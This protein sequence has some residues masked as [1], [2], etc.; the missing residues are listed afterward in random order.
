MLLALH[1]HRRR[2]AEILDDGPVVGRVRP[3]RRRLGRW[4]DAIGRDHGAQTRQLSKNGLQEFFELGLRV[5]AAAGCTFARY[6]LPHD[7]DGGRAGAGCRAAAAGW[8]RARSGPRLRRAILARPP[9]D[10]RPAPPCA[11][12]ALPLAASER[13]RGQGF[14]TPLFNVRV[15]FDRVMCRLA[16]ADCCFVFCHCNMLMRALAS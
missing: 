12:A 13:G 16:A 4:R 2:G 11:P 5:P 14:F 1:Q 8:G 6:A 15:F 10:P 9:A 7:T 3:E